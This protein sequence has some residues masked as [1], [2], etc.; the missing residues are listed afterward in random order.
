MDKAFYVFSVDETP[1]E[2]IHGGWI[3]RRLIT[4]KATGMDVTFSLGELQPGGGHTW[5]VHET[6]DEGLF[7]LAG[8]GTM[9]VEGYED[10][11]YYPGMVIVIRRGVR[12]QNINTGTEV[13]RTIAIFT[14]A[15]F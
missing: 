13:V 2:E 9:S 5:H 6:Q 15:L 12:H 14:P 7:F 10:V 1:T 3:V 11:K 4:R 8:E